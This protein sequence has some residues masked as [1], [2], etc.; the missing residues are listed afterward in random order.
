METEHKYE[1]LRRVPRYLLEV[2]GDKNDVSKVL[3]FG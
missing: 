3:E 1:I 2:L